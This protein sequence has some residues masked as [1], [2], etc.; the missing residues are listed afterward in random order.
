M[1][2]STKELQRVAKQVELFGKKYAP[3]ERVH[4]P[5]GKGIK[6]DVEKLLPTILKA[7]GLEEIAKVRPIVMAQSL[8]GTD[9]TKNFG[10]ILGG[11]KP[12]DKCTRCPIT[13]KLMFATD[14]KESTVQ[15][16][17][18]ASYHP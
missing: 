2:P 15:S 13:K 1:I 4:K 6:F 16:E 9:V 3:F 11:F 8:D 7:Y 12:K 17:T 14:P 18:T 5:T 10:C